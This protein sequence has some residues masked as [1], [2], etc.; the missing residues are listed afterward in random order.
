V[1]VEWRTS[2]HASF[3]FESQINKVKGISMLNS[4]INLNILL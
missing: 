4:F 2:T 1:L 3:P